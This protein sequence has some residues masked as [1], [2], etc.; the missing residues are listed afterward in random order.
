[1]PKPQTR[2]LANAQLVMVDEWLKQW[3]T[4]F[5]NAEHNRVNGVAEVI[6]ELLDLRSACASIIVGSSQ[7]Q[8]VEAT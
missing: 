1:M 7:R 8:K 4:L 6:D 2:R 3:Q 5:P